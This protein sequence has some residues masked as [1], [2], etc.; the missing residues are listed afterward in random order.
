MTKVVIQLS[1][2]RIDD[3]TTYRRGDVV[4]MPNALIK[5]LGNSV[6]RL[7]DVN[8]V[9]D[10]VPEALQKKD[11]LIKTLKTEIAA[12]KLDIIARKDADTAKTED[13]STDAAT[14]SNTPTRGRPTNKND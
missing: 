6:K 14:P 8:R 10:G 9:H 3:E 4:D 2:I 7:S 13:S 11:A 5:K 1:H 12:L